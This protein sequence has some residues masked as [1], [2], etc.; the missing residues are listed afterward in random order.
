MIGICGFSRPAGGRPRRAKNARPYRAAHARPTAFVFLART[1]TSG[2]VT[3]GRITP[4]QPDPP[5]NQTSPATRPPRRPDPPGGQVH[6]AVK[7]A[8]RSNRRAKNA[9]P[10]R[11]AHARPTAFVFLARTFTSG[12][13]TDYPPGDQ[14]CPATRPSRR[15]DLPGN[16]THPATRPT[17]Q[18]DLPGDQTSP[19]TRPTRRPDP[20]GG[21]VHPAVKS[22]RRSNRRS[23]ALPAAHASA[24]GSASPTF[25][26]GRVTSGRITPPATRPAR[27]PDPP[28]GQVHPAVKSARRSNRRAKNAKPY[29]AAHARPTAFVFLARTF[30]SG[31]VTSGRITPPATRPPRRPDPPGGQVHPAV[32]SARRSN[33][34]R[35]SPPGGQTAG[36]KMPSPTGLPMRGQRPSYF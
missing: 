20:P 30:T 6:P 8:R 16:Q 11:A 31:R 28:G 25:T 4:R 33:R 13:V 26:S 35:S 2:R 23:N 21:Q 10:Y 17:R 34:R 14:T 3:S 36:L 7:S 24:N 15:P 12:R 1:F 32:K 19:A 9:K 27:Q 5:G 22:A 18:P 29:R